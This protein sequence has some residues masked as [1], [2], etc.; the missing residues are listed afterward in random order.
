MSTP[1]ARARHFCEAFG[2]R[3]PILQAPMAGASP[4]AL[5]AAVANAGGLGGCGALLMSPGE[6]TGWMGAVRASSNGAVQMNLWIPDPPPVRDAARE[7]AAR[8]AFARLGPLPPEPGPGPFIQDFAA[9]CEAILAAAPPVVST[10]MGLWEPAFVRE[11][12]ARGI[13]WIANATTLEEALAAEAAG[14]DA[15]VAQGAEAGGHR[16]SFEDAAAEHQL[17]GLFV[18][19]PRLADALRVPVIATGG[20]MDGRG[21]AAALALGASAAQLGTAFLRC[22]ETALPAAWT[23]ALP[24][25]RPE[26]TVLTRGFSGRLGRGIANAA[27]R[28][29]AEVEPAPYPIQRVLAGP[30]RAEAQKAGDGERMQM[31]A[32]QGAAMARAEAAGEVVERAWREAGALLG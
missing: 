22:P 27:T 13:K 15:V 1:A 21:V 6:I 29:F 23:E 12:K 18:L 19:L 9:Q 10:I 28:V 26:D 8:Q 31:W 20:I 16:G 11:L 25:T 24:R 17:T 14:A 3:V 32:G 4:P 2:L 5:A 7:E 30:M